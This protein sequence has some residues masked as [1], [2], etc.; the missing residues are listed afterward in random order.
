VSLKLL[1]SLVVAEVEGGLVML[2]LP[3]VGAVP[4]AV[5]VIVSSP[6]ESE[7]HTADPALCAWPKSDGE[8]FE[9]RQLR[10][11]AAIEA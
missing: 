1:V 11:E 2:M 4:V 8:Q 10:A 3:V 7:E 9:R 6:A 5:D